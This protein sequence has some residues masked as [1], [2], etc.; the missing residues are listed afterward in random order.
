MALAA[1]NVKKPREAQIWNCCTGN[2]VLRILPDSN[3][4]QYIS[5]GC[6]K[7]ICKKYLPFYGLHVIYWLTL[8][9]GR[10]IDKTHYLLGRVRRILHKYERTINKETRI[11]TPIHLADRLLPLCI[12]ASLQISN[13]H[14]LRFLPF[15][16]LTAFWIFDC[17]STFGLA[18]FWQRGFLLLLKW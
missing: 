8:Q 2:P 11:L 10:K 9:H 15:C 4:K 6:E 13:F 7:D 12:L 1:I 17:M 18:P 3:K 5:L 16:I 14:C